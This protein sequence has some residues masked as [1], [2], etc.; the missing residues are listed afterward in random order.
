MNYQVM[1]IDWRDFNI[2]RA[3]SGSGFACALRHFR[4]DGIRAMGQI[5]AAVNARNALALVNPAH[6][7][8]RQARQFGAKRL[9][10]LA[11][12]IETAARDCVETQR[13]PGELA[14]DV[15][16]L[17]WAFVETLRHFDRVAN[18]AVGRAPPRAPARRPQWT[19]RTA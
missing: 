4:E 5:E 10:H 1:T 9:A 18:P 6:L 8:Q 7:L 13:C 16:E 12:L 17:R 15:A 14:K 11:A 19:E 2:C 3:E